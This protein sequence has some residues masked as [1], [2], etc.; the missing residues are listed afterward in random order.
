MARIRI[1]IGNEPRSYREA[2][3]AVVLRLRP[4]LDV[5]QVEPAAVDAEVERLAPDLVF[6][7]CLPPRAAGRHPLVWLTLYPQGR[8]MASIVIG[9]E[10]MHLDDIHVSGILSLITWAEWLTPRMS[11]AA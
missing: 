11:A 3:T 7:S 4:N 10:A 1:V 6:A 9:G 8:R 2:L 5:V